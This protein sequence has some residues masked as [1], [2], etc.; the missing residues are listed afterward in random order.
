MRT[1]PNLAKGSVAF[2]CASTG[3]SHDPCNP[4]QEG[5]ED[6]SKW[7]FTLSERGWRN[8]KSCVT[9]VLK[10]HFVNYTKRKSHFNVNYFHL[11]TF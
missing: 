4:W 7:G 11:G 2:Y 5:L 1:G 6:L 8:T 10:K 3:G 9:Y